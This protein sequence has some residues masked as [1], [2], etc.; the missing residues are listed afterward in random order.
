MVPQSA[1]QAVVL[2]GHSV[3]GKL[4]VLPFADRSFAVELAPF[5]ILF[6]AAITGDFFADLAIEKKTIPLLTWLGATTGASV[7]LIAVDACLGG[8]YFW[9]NPLYVILQAPFLGGIIGA[10]VDIPL[11]IYRCARK[12]KAPRI[13]F[14]EVFLIVLIAGAFLWIV[15][16]IQKTYQQV[17]LPI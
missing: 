8:L 15:L 3:L 9:L 4:A 2:D 6:V 17:V 12:Q 16:T 11:L 7:S 14:L 10:M 5:V 1:I 13:A